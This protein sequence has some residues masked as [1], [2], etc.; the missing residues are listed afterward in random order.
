MNLFHA[1]F[2]FKINFDI[3]PISY[4]VK[5]IIRHK[6]LFVHHGRQKTISQ[7]ELSMNKK[8]DEAA[9]IIF[10]KGALKA[11]DRVAKDADKQRRELTALLQQLEAQKESTN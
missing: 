9:K 8:N 10:I 1:P 4:I 7:G 11:L 3:N 2:F 6:S 5:S